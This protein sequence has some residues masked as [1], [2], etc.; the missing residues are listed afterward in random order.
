MILRSC[1]YDKRDGTR[2]G[3]PAVNGYDGC[4]SHSRVLRAKRRREYNRNPTLTVYGKVP[5][6]VLVRLALALDVPRLPASLRKPL[7]DL[8]RFAP[9]TQ[10]AAR[11]TASALGLVRPR[12]T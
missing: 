7:P 4:Y 12:T 5:A 11:Q 10:P 9:R 3:S 2:C 1:P 8:A 6:R